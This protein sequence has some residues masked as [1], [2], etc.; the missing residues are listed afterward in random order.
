MIYMVTAM[1][2]EAHAIITHFR[3]K[4]DLSHIRFQV[5]DNR[6]AD[7]RL[8][9]TGTGGISAA[10]AIADICREVKAGD[11]L[12]NVG[13]CAVMQEEAG[14]EKENDRAVKGETDDGGRSFDRREGTGR[15]GDIFLCNKIREEVTGRT[16]YPDIL[17]RHGFA[18]AQI[19]TGAA[20]YT[21]NKREDGF[22]L[23]DMEAAAVYQAGLYFFGPHRMSFLKVVSDDGNTKEVTDRQVRELIERNVERIA[24]Y[25]NL[26]KEAGR[27]E[28]EGPGLSVHKPDEE[29]ELLC[30]DMHCSKTMAA[31]LR[32]CIYYGI[33][34]GRDIAKLRKEMYREGVLPCRD[35][36]EGKLC[37]EEFKRRIL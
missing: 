28:Q 16:F 18:E 21:K 27:K 22:W 9:V 26:L 11:F 13:T 25:V 32:Q 3:L 4:K 20:L 23:Y 5:F 35:K 29:T 8:M 7:I 2:A 10:V 17:Y 15:P 30:R 1:Y 37:L 19:L 6:E 34:S 33:L 36:R 12:I 31:A 14:A 24:E